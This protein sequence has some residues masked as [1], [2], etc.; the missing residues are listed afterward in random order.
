MGQIKPLTEE[1]VKYR[2][3]SDTERRVAESVKS[4]YKK[5]PHSK[6]RAAKMW[7]KINEELGKVDSDEKEA[8]K[9]QK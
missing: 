8:P 6:E 9:I 5:L 1:Q 2:E 4:T 3:N 7:D